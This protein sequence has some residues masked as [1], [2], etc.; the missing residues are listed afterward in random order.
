MATSTMSPLADFPM[1]ALMV[2]QG[3]A[4]LRQSLAS[5]PPGATYQGPPAKLAPTDRR[6]TRLDKNVPDFIDSPPPTARPRKKQGL[7]EATM[8][9]GCATHLTPAS[10]R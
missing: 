10:S 6:H 9:A 4:G 7:N 5:R 8:S 1:A 2:A 3:V